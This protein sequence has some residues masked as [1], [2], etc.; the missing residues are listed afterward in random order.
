MP[1]LLILMT[2]LAQIISATRQV[3]ILPAQEAITSLDLDAKYDKALKV[4]GSSPAYHCSDPANDIYQITGMVFKHTNPRVWVYPRLPLFNDLSLMSSNRRFYQDIYL[5]G[6]FTAPTGDVPVS[7]KLMS[8][9]S[10]TNQL[11]NIL[12][13][14][15]VALYQRKHQWPGRI[16]CMVRLTSMWSWC[17]SRDHSAQP[18]R[19]PRTAF[20]IT[21]FLSSWYCKG[22]RNNIYTPAPTVSFQG[23]RWWVET[24]SRG[25][26]AK[27]GEVFLRAGCSQYYNL[28]LYYRDRDPSKGYMDDFKDNNIHF[29]MIWE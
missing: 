4:P 25:Y 24:Q 29:T 27:R 14:V 15:S 9:E 28:T 17:L 22:L 3:P 1:R 12:T 20:W 26:N 6:H 11:A 21:P 18:E 2:L 8:Y 13:E 16:R 19:R 10:W 7:K 5:T 23:S